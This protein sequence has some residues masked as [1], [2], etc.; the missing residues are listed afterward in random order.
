MARIADDR[1][2]QLRGARS[3]AVDVLVIVPGVVLVLVVLIVDRLLAFVPLRILLGRVV[4]LVVVLAV[5]LVIPRIVV[6][7]PVLVLVLVL[8]VEVILVRGG[9]ADQCFRFELVFKVFIAFVQVVVL[10]LV[11]FAVGI[12]LV[13]LLVDPVVLDVVRLLVRI[14]VDRL[15]VLV[16]LVVVLVELV[17]FVLVL[18]VVRAIVLDSVGLLLDVVWALRVFVRLVLVRRLLLRVVLVLVVLVRDGAVVVRILVLVRLEIEVVRSVLVREIGVGCVLE[19]VVEGLVVDEGLA[20]RFLDGPEAEGIGSG[21]VVVVRVGVVEGIAGRVLVVRGA[22]GGGGVVAGGEGLGGD[23]RG[24]AGTRIVPAIGRGGRDAG[25]L[26]PMI[27]GEGGVLLGLGREVVEQLLS[28]LGLRRGLGALDAGDRGSRGGLRALREGGIARGIGSGRAGR[29]DFEGG[30]RGL[31][32]G[33]ELG[34][35]GPIGV[36]VLGE[37]AD[38]R[39]LRAGGGEGDLLADELVGADADPDDLGGLRLGLGRVGLLAPTAPGL[40]GGG[41]G[42]GRGEV[43]VGGAFWSR[44]GG[45]AGL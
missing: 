6:A 22:V 25:G 12:V 39:G 2:G 14:L 34:E 17:V 18:V 10:G 4:D 32:L 5:E 8:L 44:G 24:G 27:F 35:L 13:R 31:G 29:E 28:R 33:R 43:R 21:I 15:L 38:G 11:V 19:G 36:G 3:P 7:V 40:G 23:D 1:L 16:E 20:V 9:L 41:R 42:L 37:G 45:G 26:V 30:V